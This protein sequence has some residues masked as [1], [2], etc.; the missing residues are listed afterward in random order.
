MAFNDMNTTT[1][2]NEDFLQ[3]VQGELEQSRR[4][5]KEISLLYEQSQGELT[6]LTQRNA[7]IT[8]HMQQMQAQFESIPRADIRMAYTSALDAQQ[9]LLVMRGQLEKMQSDQ[10]HLQKLV[11]YL[12]K[13]SQFLTSGEQSQQGK[14]GSTN[15]LS[16]LIKAQEAERQRLSRQMHDGPAQALSNFIVQTE[17]AARLLEMDPAKAKEEL[18][19]L[20]TTAMTTFQKV[21]SFI[22][23]LRPMM[24][25]DL[26][27]VPTLR[28]YID[29]F[30]EQSGVDVNLT[31]KG[32]ER[33][34]D[35]TSE[36]VVFRAVQ[37]L[38]GNAARHNANQSMKVQI[39]VQLSIESLVMKVVVTD[40]G[41]GFDPSLITQ[42]DGI[43]LKLIRERIEM[44]DG[45]L[46]IDTAIGKGCKITL[47]VPC[48]DAKA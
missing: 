3:V 19:S 10:G 37:E 20:K 28:R 32:K 42:G 14:G 25:D 34:L 40:N 2:S 22:F 17:I 27:L 18:N 1:E 4:A 26:G 6:K 43:G 13:M 48:V 12:E 41:K 29:S 7:A 36:V 39:N 21:R 44:L 24:L 47:Q 38:M 15:I 11:S 45:N 31:V 30:K 23:E 35:S 9:R 5:L 46:D 8:G 33:R 16:M